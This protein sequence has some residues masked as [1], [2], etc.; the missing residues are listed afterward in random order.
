MTLQK[1]ILVVEDNAINRELLKEILSGQYS[2]LEAANGKEALEL[3]R[4]HKEEVAL[5]LL[6]VMMPVMD[7]YTLLDIIKSDSELSLIPVIVTTQSNSEEDEINALSHGATDFVPKPYKPQVILHRIASIIN[8]RE[9][10]AMVNQ[11]QYDPLTGLQ[12]KEFF[13]RK[14]EETLRQYPTGTYALICSDVENFKLYND[15]FGMAAGDEL[16]KQIAVQ[17][18]EIAGAQGICGRQGA[19][20]F[21][22]LCENTGTYS[23]AKLRNFTAQL[24]RTVGGHVVIK[25]GIYEIKD[26]SVSVEQMCDRAF[27]AAE[28]IKG[29]YKKDVSRY[30]DELRERMLREQALTEIM[31]NALAEEQFEV[32]LQPKYKVE[33][34]LLAGAEALVRW[35]H[36]ERGFI[37]PGDF[38]PL[39][40]KNGF[41]TQLDLYIWEQVCKILKSWEEKGYP[42]I[43]VS[44]NVSRADVY[45]IDLVDMMK[46][47]VEKYEIHPA[48]LHLE[49]TE[50]AY[51][52]NAAQITSTVDQL[53]KAGFVIEMDDFGSGYSSLN[54]LNQMKLDILKLDMKF[55]Q[56][57]IAKSVEQ[58]I[59]YFIV[60]LA[61]WMGL[62]VIAEGV[63]T[64]EQLERLREIGCDYVQGYFFS[65]PI[66]VKEFEDLLQ[67]A[68][69]LKMR[70]NRNR[71]C[72]DLHIQRLLVV[73]ED[74]EYRSMVHRIFEKQFKVVEAFSAEEIFAQLQQHKR[75]FSVIL[76]SMTLPNEESLR[77]LD[78]VGTFRE[79][80]KIPVLATAG[81]GEYSKMLEERAMKCGADDFAWKPHTEYSLYKRVSRL[82]GLNVSRERQYQLESEACT[83]MATG[84]YNRRG[85]EIA[86]GKLCKDDLPFAVYIFEL[87]GEKEHWKHK[88]DSEKA[89]LNK[90]FST[91]LKMHTRK[92]DLLAHYGEDG[93]IAVLKKIPSDEIAVKKGEEICRV[94]Y[95][96]QM[97]DGECI[98]C[99]V[100][101]TRCDSEELLSARMIR[102]ADEAL[103]CARKK[104]NGGC[105]M[106]REGV[107]CFDKLSC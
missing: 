31:E 33:G 91:L 80:W 52:E 27:L 16:L 15:L 82:M 65:K 25:W 49:I 105:L 3:L 51:T 93:F 99:S 78:E 95:E 76:L 23:V 89:S 5:V 36:P 22:C 53:R 8:L 106:W 10:A 41:I 69:I 37:S 9:T 21:M 96:Q 81:E 103:S 38:I 101:I 55:I 66:P 6:D 74:P 97:E 70:L 20:R 107:S 60:G 86:L 68:P 92:G 102:Q 40:E 12:N 87:E 13:Y 35:N 26:R 100:G 43:P 85:F 54:M 61:K 62:N 46:K 34:E 39:F 1:Q 17:L 57:E 11:F 32:Y 24:N 88:T 58:G 45:Q 72:D 59:L 94:F 30:D 47:L 7:G 2:V 104:K 77:I 90:R 73:D 14:V 67:K 71:A 79:A 28:R 98:K 63:E 42:M 56:S 84:L 4:S 64:R 75:G 44:I 48:M 19:D 29:Q 50:S 18:Q 83:D